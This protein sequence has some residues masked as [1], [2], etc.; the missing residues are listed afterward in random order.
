M[1]KQAVR[2][3]RPKGKTSY[4]PVPARAF[5]AVVR[6]LRLEKELTQEALSHLA[7]LEPSH[8][9]K[10]ESGTHVPNLILVLKLAAALG[11]AAADL[12][13]QT[14]ARLEELR[15]QASSSDDSP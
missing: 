10:V 11:F 12:V 5:G 4:D 1:Q 9:S 15:S 2:R 3:G 14:E 6:K 8:M 13:Q 7:G